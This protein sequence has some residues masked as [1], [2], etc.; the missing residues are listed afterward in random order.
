MRIFLR[1]ENW[2]DGLTGD[3]LTRTCRLFRQRRFNSSLWLSAFVRGDD[4]LR[5][6]GVATMGAK[7]RLLKADGSKSGAPRAGVRYPLGGGWAH[8]NQGIFGDDAHFRSDADLPGKL[9]LRGQLALL[10]LSS[11]QHGKKASYH[12]AV[13]FNIELPGQQQQRDPGCLPDATGWQ[14]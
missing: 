2:G 9:V 12:S 6:L 13:S 8:Q 10:D 11:L 7:K 14:I 4:Y 5:R 1:V 3:L